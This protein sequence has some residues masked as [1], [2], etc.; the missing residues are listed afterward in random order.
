MVQARQIESWVTAA[1]RGDQLAIAKL[2]AT[3]HPKLHAR[4]KVRMD[5]ALQVR[6]EP[7][8][9]LQDVYIQVLHERDRFEDRGTESF[10]NWVCK[11][12]DNKLID[13]R[14]AARRQ[15]RD[16][17]R[18]VSIGP[19]AGTGSYWNLLDQ[20]FADASS[21]SGQIRGDE[22]IGAMLACLSNLSEAHRQVLQLRFLQ[23]MPVGEVAGHL[24]K[25]DAAIVALSR[26]ALE[27]LRKSMD[28]LGEF[29]HGG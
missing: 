10:L 2:L 19:S 12:L 9:I 8:D 5:P 26:R 4:A 28:H 17:E 22:A 25:S 20:I 14:R 15:V 11:I 3:Y 21:P 29:T 27:A 23:G 7:E 13:A 1:A 6:L 18:E 24:H 16:V